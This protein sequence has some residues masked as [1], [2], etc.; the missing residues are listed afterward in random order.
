MG[1]AHE[2]IAAAFGMTPEELFA[3]Q[4]AGKTIAQLAEEQGVDLETVVAAAIGAHKD[5]LAARVQAGEL[6]QAQPDQAQA[7]M[8]PRIRE[9]VVGLYGPG[10]RGGR[11]FGPGMG[12]GRRGPGMGPGIG[13]GFG[14]RWQDQ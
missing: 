8:E 3:A 2:A 1:V 5:A 7:R 11:G 12:P 9:H 4:R 13:P 10:D 14:P 6:T